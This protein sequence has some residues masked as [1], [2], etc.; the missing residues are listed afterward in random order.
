MD[1]A[2]GK[3][4]DLAAL[5]RLDETI[6]LEE[7]RCRYAEDKIYVSPVCFHCYVNKQV[8]PSL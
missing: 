1:P 2:R 3:T 7:L 4:D 6:L 8:S 5:S